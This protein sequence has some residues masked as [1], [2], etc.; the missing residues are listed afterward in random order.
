MNTQEKGKLTQN[1]VSKNCSY[2]YEMIVTIMHST[3][4]KWN[5]KKADNIYICFSLCKACLNVKARAET[6]GYVKHQKFELKEKDM[7]RKIR[8][9]NRLSYSENIQIEHKTKINQSKR[10]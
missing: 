8:K 9:Y 5:E 1:F 4:K 3:D 7:R 6:V 10:K 2:L